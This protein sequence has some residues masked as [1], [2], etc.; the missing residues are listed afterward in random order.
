MGTISKKSIEGMIEIMQPPFLDKRGLFKNLFRSNENLFL[1]TWGERAIK[2]INF[3]KT[4]K[5]GTI[6]GLHY[7]CEPFLEAKL[8]SC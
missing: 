3:S 7:Q 4:S 8:I 1:S 2:Q 6:R 5:K